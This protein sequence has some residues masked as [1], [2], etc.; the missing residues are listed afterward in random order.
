MRYQ[1]VVCATKVGM[2][3]CVHAS[4]CLIKKDHSVHTR[5]FLVHFPT[6][7]METLLGDVCFVESDYVLLRAIKDVFFS[8][9]C[10]WI[11]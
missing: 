11:Y 7:Q 2:N 1:G 8:L 9:G 5:L 4:S 6:V 3:D 10:V